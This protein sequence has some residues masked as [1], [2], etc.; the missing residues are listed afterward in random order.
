M[1]ETQN[2][3]HSAWE[4][5]GKLQ[6][7]VL[8]A[9]FIIASPIVILVGFAP[10]V[11]GDFLYFK[12]LVPLGSIALFLQDFYPGNI[13]DLVVFGFSATQF[14]LY[15][16]VISFSRRRARNILLVFIAHCVFVIAAFICG[17]FFEQ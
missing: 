13:F 5:L 12:I 16:I 15:G 8:L 1:F 7:C 14:L 10:A 4:R 11:E 3:T 9:G 17:Y 6:P 2:S